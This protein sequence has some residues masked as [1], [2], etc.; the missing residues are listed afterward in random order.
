MVRAIRRAKLQGLRLTNSR[1]RQK[2]PELERPAGEDARGE[3]LP[4]EDGG[5][6]C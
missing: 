3:R 6:F 2:F 1:A 5:A 4:E